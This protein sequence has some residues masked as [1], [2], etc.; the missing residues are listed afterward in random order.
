MQP[1]LDRFEQVARQPLMSAGGVAVEEADDDLSHN[2][3]TLAD[4]LD[5]TAH[6]VTTY[7]K[8]PVQELAILIACWIALTYTYERFRYCGYLALRS[9]TPRCGKTRVLRILSLLVLGSPSITTSPT[10]PVL[11]RSLRPVLILDEVDRLRNADKDNFGAVISILNVG[12][13][14]GAVVERTERIKGGNFE[15]KE[16]PVYR[17]VAMAGIESLADTLSDRTFQIRM[18]RTP[19]RMPRFSV[20]LLDELAEQLRAGFQAWAD[21]HGHEA[22]VAYDQLPDELPE[23]KSFDDRFQDI[24]E[25]L[26]VLATLADSQ[27][28]DGP[29]VLPRLL[30]GLHAAAGRREPSGRERELLVFLEILQPLLADEE[31]IFLPSST[32]VDLCQEREELSRIET[33]R[34]LAGFLK[35]FDLFTK[36]NGKVRG[37]A[38]RRDWVTNWGTRYAW[39]QVLPPL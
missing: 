5:E 29:A 2:T 20:R 14:K 16:F 27:R 39:E 30:K 3:P 19:E 32:L 11:F 28:L 31:E 1:D 9:A 4:L 10:A 22:E 35:H 12:F 24:A 15:V 25:P 21:H 17:P 36:S 18:E 38:I 13:E 26:I 37:Y 6:L 33:G 34:A 23:L 8:L 7:A